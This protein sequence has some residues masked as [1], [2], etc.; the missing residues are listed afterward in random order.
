MTFK[1]LLIHLL[2]FGLGFK[3]D[4]VDVALTFLN[5]ANKVLFSLMRSLQVFKQQ[6]L[7]HIDL[8]QIMNGFFNLD[9]CHLPIVV[10]LFNFQIAL[11]QESLYKSRMLLQR[12]RLLLQKIDLAIKIFP[13]GL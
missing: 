4:K 12:L 7:L 11:F 5:L 13:L 9:T 2:L 8:V 3:L 1:Q 10:Q 6:S